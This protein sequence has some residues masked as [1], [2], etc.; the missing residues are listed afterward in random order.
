MTEFNPNHGDAHPQFADLV[1]LDLESGTT[2]TVQPMEW[3][4]A[5]ELDLS[6]EFDGECLTP[7][8]LDEARALR[9]VLSHAIDVA[10]R[11]GAE[12]N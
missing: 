7:L 2:A 11:R 6:S 3:G 10:T 1:I 8:T 4:R 9:Q 12:L 5:I